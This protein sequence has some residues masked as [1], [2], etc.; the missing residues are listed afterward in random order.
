MIDKIRT[1]LQQQK[2]LAENSGHIVNASVFQQ[3]IDSLDEL[4]YM[5]EKG[6]HF[7]ETEKTILGHLYNMIEQSDVP[8]FKDMCTFGEFLSWFN[9][10]FPEML[11]KH[12]LYLSN[13]DTKVSYVNLPMTYL[14]AIVMIEPVYSTINLIKDDKVIG[15]IYFDDL[16]LYHLCVCSTSDYEKALVGSHDTF[17]TDY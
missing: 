9:D 12:V 16:D 8:C 17:T 14:D 1:F 11:S 13:G 4:E 5:Q 3:K 10:M 7:K 15:A 2:T 6:F